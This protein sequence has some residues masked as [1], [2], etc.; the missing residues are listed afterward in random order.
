MII[1][2][3]I[4]KQFQLN[5]FYK[6]QLIKFIKNL[7]ISIKSLEKLKTKLYLH[8]LTIRAIS[9]AGSEHPELTS[10]GSGFRNKQK[11]KRG[12][13]A[14]LVQSTSFT[15]RGSGVRTPHR[16]PLFQNRG[17]RFGFFYYVFSLYFI[18]YSS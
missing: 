13:L 18:F 2:S 3:K 14:Q 17:F 16:P 10:G 5:P 8:P 15:P 6:L 7:I 11:I 1:L 12:R 9:S 4:G